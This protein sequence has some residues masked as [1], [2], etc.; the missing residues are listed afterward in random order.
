VIRWLLERP[1]ALSHSAWAGFRS[2][3]TFVE[4]R[5]LG[6][7]G[8]GF[9]F[10]FNWRFDVPENPEERTYVLV[11]AESSHVRIS[12][13]LFL[14][15]QALSSSG[16]VPELRAKLSAIDASWSTVSDEELLEGVR[17][18]EDAGIAPLGRSLG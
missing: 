4:P 2:F 7:T 1:D 18:C 11:R 9:A 5:T 14:L 3:A 8:S 17:S 10:C 13:D 12:A 15:A 16:S 6:A